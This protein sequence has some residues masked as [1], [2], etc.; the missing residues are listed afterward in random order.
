M[1]NYISYSGWSIN[2]PAIGTGQT[3]SISGGTDTYGNPI[4][5]YLFQTYRVP[6]GTVSG[7]AWYTW[8]V[9]TASTNNQIISQ[10]G[11]NNAGNPNALTAVNTQPSI[12]NLSV[13]NTGST[14]PIGV[15]K[16]YSTYTS[17]TF[18]INGTVN[19]IYFKGNTLI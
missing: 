19:D 8:I 3:S 5:A 14:I 15:Y 17:P 1:N 9:P 13:T 2:S 18:R 10:I 6:A 11:Y 4:D 16:V 12:Y 7:D